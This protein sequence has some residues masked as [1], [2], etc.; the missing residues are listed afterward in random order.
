MEGNCQK[1]GTYRRSLHR[2]H[3]LPKFK[4]G[5]DETDN[6]QYICANCHEDKTRIDLL[7]KKNSTETRAKLSAALRGRTFSEEAITK[8]RVAR[9]GTRHT[10]ETKVKMRNAKIGEKN[11]RFQL[12]EFTID[13]LPKPKREN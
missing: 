2:D 8:M 6:I 10:E 11:P 3:I 12:D 4:G 7:G 5:S 1:C 9:T 13:T